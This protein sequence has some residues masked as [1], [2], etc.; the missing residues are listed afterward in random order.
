[1][2]DTT[3][4]WENVQG[5][6]HTHDATKPTIT[7][8]MFHDRSPGPE[9]PTTLLLAIIRAPAR[10][11]SDPCTISPA[12]SHTKQA[13]H[14]VFILTVTRQSKCKL[15]AWDRGSAACRRDSMLTA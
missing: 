5:K 6:R 13:I 14:G 3:G 10:A 2:C 9:V 12:G 8:S 15:L 7:V 1:M 11:S 4:S